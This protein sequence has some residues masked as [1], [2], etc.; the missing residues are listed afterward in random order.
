M[1]GE[2]KIN[3]Y[4]SYLAG[5]VFGFGFAIMR[6]SLQCVMDNALMTFAHEV[7]IS[8]HSHY[9]FKFL[10]NEGTDFIF[11]SRTD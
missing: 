6:L 10:S 4:S 3:N 11:L 1:N 8:I 9:I 5:K 7:Y 2:A